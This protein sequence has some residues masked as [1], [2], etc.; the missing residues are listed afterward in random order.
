M[1]SVRFGCSVSI[2]FALSFSLPVK[3][4]LSGASNLGRAVLIRSLCGRAVLKYPLFSKVLYFN[5]AFPVGITASCVT[6]Q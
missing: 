4:Q 2:S 1:L 5:L 3:E 6:L